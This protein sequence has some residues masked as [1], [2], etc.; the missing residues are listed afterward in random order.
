MIIRIISLVL[1]FIAWTLFVGC[2]ENKQKTFDKN[3]FSVIDNNY[4]Y[5]TI[6]YNHVEK[7]ITENEIKNARQVENGF[8]SI[9]FFD[10]IQINPDTA[11]IFSAREEKIFQL[12]DSA[13]V[14][15]KTTIAQ[16]GN[17][18]DQIQKGIRFYI[19]DEEIYLIQRFRVSE[20]EK[21]DESGSYSLH[22]KRTIPLYVNFYEELD[23]ESALVVN[24]Y[25]FK[26]E[27][28]FQK[29]SADFKSIEKEIGG[30][31]E[32]ESPNLNKSFN[33]NAV[34]STK[35]QTMYA[36]VFNFLPYVGLFN[37]ELELKKVYYLENFIP[38][39]IE[40]SGEYEDDFKRDN[41]R[42]HTSLANLL[43]LN[44][45]RIWLAFSD[46]QSIRV[47]PSEF[48]NR[49]VRKLYHYFI[50]ES[51]MTMKHVGSSEYNGVLFNNRFLFIKDDHLH[52]TDEI[53]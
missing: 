19:L 14:L 26:N 32:S 17:G 42:L 11:F 39:Q 18:P 43:P 25:T 40:L 30:Y 38:S 35:S 23:D 46:N 13:G 52:I 12:A 37:K 5:Q 28:S 48:D 31:I 20:L 1:F 34:I 27:T 21:R 9:G 53:F 15:K 24:T 8:L 51:D 49:L 2:N 50:I 33:F 36:Q 29:V 22:V 41:A 44:D 16:Q 10:F 45:N 4:D 7:L 6:K 47:G 3:P